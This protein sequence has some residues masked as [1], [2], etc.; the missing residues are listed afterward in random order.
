MDAKVYSRKLSD[1]SVMG[2]NVKTRTFGRSPSED[3]DQ[4]V[5]SQSL[6]RI[7]TGQILDS[8]EFVNNEDW[9]DCRMR[10]LI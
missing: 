4:S 6:I 2:R 5:H 10:R 3:S 7:Y 8:Q 9:S 1:L